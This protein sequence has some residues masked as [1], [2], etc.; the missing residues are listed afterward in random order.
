MIPQPNF[1]TFQTFIKFGKFIMSL[2]VTCKT[3][4][5]ESYND[6]N[7]TQNYFRPGKI[8]AKKQKKPLP[9]E[10]VFVIKIKT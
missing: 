7:Y 6:I 10:I 2:V 9:R 4:Y 1:P 3:F 8:P 5:M